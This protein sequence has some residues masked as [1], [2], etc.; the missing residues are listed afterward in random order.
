MAQHIE[1]IQTQS[2]TISVL[3]IHGMQLLQMNSQ[4]LYEYI[5]DAAVE[6]PVIELS[7]KSN[8]STEHSQPLDKANWIMVNDE[9]NRH[10]YKGES[11]EK[12]VG[13]EYD[14]PFYDSYEH[15]LV[16]YL[17]LQLETVD[18]SE[19]TTT[20]ARVLAEFVDDAGYI[21]ESLEELQCFTGKSKSVVRRGIHLLQTLEPSGVGAATLQECLH[22]QLKRAGIR[23]LAAKIVDDFLI[24]A[25]QKR[26]NL[27]ADATG[28]SIE[29]VT[30]A[31]NTICSLNPKPGS[32]FGRTTAD[33]Y[34]QPDIL[35]EKTQDGLRAVLNDLWIP[36]ITLSPYYTKLCASTETKEIRDYLSERIRKATTQIKCIEQ[37]R[38]TI[39]VCAEEILRIQEGF[40]NRNAPLKAMTMADVAF[41]VGLNVS[42]VSR[43]V[44]GK[45]IQTPTGVL[46]I[47]SLFSRNV[48]KKKA[49]GLSSAS[50]KDLIEGFIS[51][52]DKS[53]PLS[54]KELSTM[55][56]KYGYGLSRRTI[57]KYRM[58]LGILSSA[59]RQT[60]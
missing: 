24:E 35:I 13:A 32:I 53:K 58:E 8:Y 39:L 22:I 27:I 25:S 33:L 6:N 42:T 4:E 12:T 48:G 52:E 28:K 18:S 55:L 47:S 16:D 3:Q 45:Y 23:G 46:E 41:E 60:K 26:F 29:D 15:T 7:E 2:Q 19:E 43:A 17:K 21:T 30:D 54:D 14:I 38:N 1:Q 36:T 59:E 56:S 11:T 37:R 34:I 50:A 49:D 10:L 9:Q 40:F 20:I 31:Y 44:K 57:A 5:R 51:D